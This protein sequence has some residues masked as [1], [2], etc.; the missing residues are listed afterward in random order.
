MDVEGI[1]SWRKKDIDSWAGRLV[2][3]D[4]YK[5]SFPERAT[6]QHDDAL[7]GKSRE[8]KTTRGALDLEPPPWTRIP[9]PKK[10]GQGRASQLSVQPGPQIDTIKTMQNA[11]TNPPLNSIIHHK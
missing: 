8:E 6:T 3:M 7:D 5:E 4:A 11:V 10:R 2:K 1:A 9:T